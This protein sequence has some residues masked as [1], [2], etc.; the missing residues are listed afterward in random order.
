MKITPVGRRALAVGAALVPL[1]GLFI[2]VALRSGPLAPVPVTVYTVDVRGL[3]P[4]LYGI[5]TI[6]A[7]YSYRV[8]PTAAGRVAALDVHVGDHVRAGQALGEMDGVDLDE[9]ITAQ[10]AARRAARAA[11]DEALARLNY[12]QGQLRRHERLYQEQ[13]VSAEALA[14]QRQAHDVAEAA[15]AG[16][17]RELERAGAEYAAMVAQ[18][19]NLRLV[20]PVDGLVVSRDAEPGTTVIAGQPVVELID[21]QSLWA[22]VRFDQAGAAGLTAGLP[23]RVVLRSRGS[24]RPLAGHVLRVEPRADAV[25]EELLARVTFDA[26]PE[27]LPPVGELA[28]VTV[29]L[30]ALP[31]LPV[32]PNAAVRQIGGITAVWRVVGGKPRHTPVTLGAGDLDGMLQ[33]RDGLAAGD[34]IVVHS[35]S[36]VHARTRLRI[37]ER[38]SGVSVP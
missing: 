20:A 16:A 27:P 3:A 36:A 34:R 14:A 4:A 23:A 6:E 32:I 17:R 37:V 2:W 8:G 33:V 25:T 5:G 38:I 9:R 1:M 15:L 7:R 13:L 12:A 35:A 18:R 26:Q 21:P 10:A 28:E 11:L 30:A 29:A 24:D 22:D 19:A 31:P